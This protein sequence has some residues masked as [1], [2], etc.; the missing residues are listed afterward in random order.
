MVWIAILFILPAWI[1]NISF[2]ILGFI[3]RRFHI[4]DY[5][6]DF[7]K[8]F[9]DNRRIIGDSATIYGIFVGLIVGSL[10]GYLQGRLLIGF[11]M[12]IGSY[13]GHSLGSFIK[14][15]FGFRSG[16]FF[17][18]LDHTDYVIFSLILIS[19][20][21]GISLQ[22]AITIFIITLALHPLACLIG[23]WLGIKRSPW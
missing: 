16:Q 8:N 17:P 20:F 19:I 14:R 4:K 6:V 13:C 12:G 7:G 11:L 15:R 22:M 5:P 9:F 18:V 2:N 10:V 21:I 1:T 3:T 23:Y